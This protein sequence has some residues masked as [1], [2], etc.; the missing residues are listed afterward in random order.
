[1]AYTLTMDIKKPTIEDRV[2]QQEKPTTPAS[3]VPVVK[4]LGER[5]VTIG[6]PASFN[7][8]QFGLKLVPIPLSGIFKISSGKILRKKFESIHAF[9]IDDPHEQLNGKMVNSAEPQNMHKVNYTALDKDLNVGLVNLWGM[10]EAMEDRDVVGTINEEAS[11]FNKEAWRN[12]ISNAVDS[13][14]K[15]VMGENQG[16]CLIANIIY[17]N[18]IITINVGDS[19]AYLVIVAADGTATTTRLNK[20]IH[21]PH[22]KEEY[23]RLEEYARTRHVHINDL[24][25]T[26]LEGGLSLFNYKLAGELAISR[27]LGDSRFIPYGLSAEPDV[28]FTTLDLAKSEKGFVITACDGLTEPK[29]MEKKI[30]AIIAKNKKKSPEDI[31]KKLAI[32]ALNEGSE[33][34]ISVIVSVLDVKNENVKY[35]AIFDGHGG[36]LVS[37]ELRKNFHT[38]LAKQVKAQL[39]ESR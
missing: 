12:V 35:A 22:T 18:T 19:N 36:D 13:L 30:G 5:F 39:E 4:S 23:E 38:E 37:E 14:Q 9:T 28:H 25:P 34:N 8:Q 31:A 29:D 16:S 21:S 24:V 6:K 27:A 7:Y 3:V 17:K 26:T 20:T 10:R 11:Q 15:K 2:T 32:E 33:D 1:M